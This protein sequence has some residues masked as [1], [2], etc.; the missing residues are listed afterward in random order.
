MRVGRQSVGRAMRL[1]DA[2]IKALEARGSTV[3]VVERD[4]R[5]QTRVKILDETI[6]IELR[7]GLN[8]REK[9]FI[10]AELLRDDYSA[11]RRHG[12]AGQFS[13]A[14]AQPKTGLLLQDGKWG[15]PSGRA[16][17]HSSL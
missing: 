2:L 9:Q 14:G 4:R 10:A 15:V 12:D 11:W 1:M 3:S 17:R 8:R 6:E 7:E 13:L 16:S 5:H